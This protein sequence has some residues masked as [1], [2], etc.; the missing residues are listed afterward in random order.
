MTEKVALTI[1]ISPS[2]LVALPALAVINGTREECP[3]ESSALIHR[4]A[5]ERY[6][7][8][9]NPTFGREQGMS[10][11]ATELFEQAEERLLEAVMEAV[12]K[13]DIS[14]Y[15]LLIENATEGDPAP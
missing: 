14:S 15:S 2:L 11:I 6:D 10:I 12:D 3:N 4:M 13:E 9:E 8:I 5:A 1:H 7:A